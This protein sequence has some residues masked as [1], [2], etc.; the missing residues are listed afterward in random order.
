MDFLYKKVMEWLF[1]AAMANSDR[2]KSAVYGVITSA[3]VLI[4][5]RCQV[6][7]AFLTPEV[8]NWI[9][10]T[11]ATLA[12]SIIAALSKR[13]IAAPNELVEGEALPEP[14]DE[15]DGVPGVK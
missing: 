6:C 8:S 14:P 5:G 9:A 11:I 3:L 7:N 13:D 12:V 4:A 10:G 1:G 15:A 2:V